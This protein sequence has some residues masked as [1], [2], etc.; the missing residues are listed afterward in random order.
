MLST[1]SHADLF[2]PSGLE[3]TTLHVSSDCGLGARTG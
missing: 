3:T 2:D 1:S